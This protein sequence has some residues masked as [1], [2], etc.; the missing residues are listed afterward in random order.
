LVPEPYTKVMSGHPPWNLSEPKR[1][2]LH[3]FQNALS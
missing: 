3:Q 2:M 1:P